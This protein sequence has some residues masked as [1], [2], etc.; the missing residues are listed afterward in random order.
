MNANRD[1]HLVNHKKQL[2]NYQFCFVSNVFFRFPPCM[3]F[4]PNPIVYCDNLDSYLTCIN[5][6]N[7]HFALGTIYVQIYDFVVALIVK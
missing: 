7:G 6:C 1:K 4:N 5:T 2:P 3:F